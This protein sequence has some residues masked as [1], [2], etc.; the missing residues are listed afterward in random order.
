MSNV[1]RAVIPA[2]GLGTRMLPATKSQPKEMLP[3]VDKPAIQY[4]VEEAVAAGIDDIIIVTSRGKATLE[5][6]FDS[7]AELEEALVRKGKT[8]ELDTVRRVAEL[9]DVHY[10]RQHAPLG[11]GHAVACA[12][13]HIGDHSFAVLLPDDLIESPTGLERMIAA[14]DEHH[15]SVI[16]LVEVTDEQI[17]S[18]GSVRP[19]PVSERLVRVHDIVEKP[20]FGEAPSNLAVIGRYI[21]TPEIFAAIDETKPGVGG[22]IQLTDAIGILNESQ[23]VYGWQL[24]ERRFDMGKKTEYLETIVE[25]ALRHPEVGPAFR[26]YLTEVVRREGLT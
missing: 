25:Y 5:D 12:R 24:A 3:I 23:P 16:A 4:V 10:V 17:V 20:A 8:A 14:H 7:T 9:A 26:A 11:L 21:F 13:R 6:H 19:E 2:A 22:E 18:L 1:T 15:A